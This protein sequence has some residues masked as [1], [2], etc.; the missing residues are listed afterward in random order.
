[1]TTGSNS[2]VGGTNTGGAQS[3]SR[4]TRRW[5]LARGERQPR[6]VA[7]YIGVGANW[8]PAVPPTRRGFRDHHRRR[9]SGRRQYDRRRQ[10][11]R[12]QRHLREF[13]GPASSTSLARRGQ[14]IQGNFIAPMLRLAP[15]PRRSGGL[16]WAYSSN[17]HCWVR[18]AGNVISGQHAR[19]R[20][21]RP[22]QFGPANGNFVQGTLSA[23]RPKWVV[24]AG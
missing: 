7:N 12:R 4:A 23:P 11:G 21:D 16:W 14:L 17:T 22:G 2:V 3:S 5:R 15:C 6:A 9:R 18:G 19:G 13:G 20:G 1:V 24:A 10:R 8:K